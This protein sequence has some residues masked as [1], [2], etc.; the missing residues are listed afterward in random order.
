MR[1]ERAPLQ[2]YGVLGDPFEQ[3][4]RL[5]PRRLPLQIRCLK[6]VEQGGEGRRRRRSRKKSRRRRKMRRKRRREGRRRKKRKYEVEV[7]KGRKGFGQV[8]SFS[9]ELDHLHFA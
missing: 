4:N 5:R 1:F 9:H 7:S 6:K 3:L 2:F 8:T